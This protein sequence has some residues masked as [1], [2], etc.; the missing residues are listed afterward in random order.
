MPQDITVTFAPHIR[1]PLST[2]R[3]ML[4][5][6]IG[7]MPA[8][9]AAA[10][11]F[12]I[13]GLAVIAV[14]VAWCAATEWLCNLVR[15]K[16]N[17]LGDFSA[18]VTGIILGLSLPP[19]LPLWAAAIGAVFA[20]GIGKMVFGGLGA[21]IFNPAMAGRLFLTASFGILMTTWTVPATLDTTMP[22]V[23]PANAIDARTQATPLAWSK[24]AIKDKTGAWI[25]DERLPLWQSLLGEKA[26]C[27][28]ETS[29]IGLLIGG[30]YLLIRRTIT[31]HI[32]LAV[33]ASAFAFA[34]IA[35]LLDSEAYVQP[36]YHLTSGALLFG[37]FFI[38]TDP[39]TAP[40]TIRGQW[41]FGI[42]IGV[43]TMLVRI[44]GEYPEGVMYAVFLANGVRPLIDRFVKPVPVGGVPHAV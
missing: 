39:V 37:A 12:R 20:I 32:P 41:I 43:F 30:V 18:V 40:M 25:Y 31:I 23:S 4:D 15:K 16:P 1:R 24:T 10:V 3:I 33:L 22:T 42:L 11:F 26:G 17:T 8:V 29:V 7:L 9:I 34:G 38:A 36:V 5:V 6:I 27:L 44:V 35:Y 14:C 13:R 21:N 19:A 28:G 2:R